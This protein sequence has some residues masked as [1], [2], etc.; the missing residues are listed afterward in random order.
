M[1]LPWLSTG[2][3]VVCDVCC[4]S[5]SFTE[6]NRAASG[7]LNS[8]SRQCLLRRSDASYFLGK[9]SGAYLPFP[10]LSVLAVASSRPILLVLLYWWQP[11]C[12]HPC[13]GYWS[14]VESV[15]S[16]S[17]PPTETFLASLGCIYKL[18]MCPSTSN[19]HASLSQLCTVF[20][21]LYLNPEQQ[22]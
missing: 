2:S 1:Q 15:A 10:V 14:G 8:S 19:S 18:D 17:T 22:G 13:T 16:H 3:A 5:E 11:A 9:C 6:H 4:T 7:H 20:Q 12:M 21:T